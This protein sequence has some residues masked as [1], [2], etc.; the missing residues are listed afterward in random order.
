MPTL[1]YAPEGSG[2]MVE[3]DTD[4]LI[5]TPSIDDHGYLQP[6][7]PGP[8]CETSHKDNVCSGDLGKVVKL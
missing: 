4:L 2:N 1:G 5:E 6:L 8:S 7:L 3:V